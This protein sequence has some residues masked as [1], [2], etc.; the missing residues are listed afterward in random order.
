MAEYPTIDEPRED[1]VYPRAEPL[2]G[3]LPSWARSE[4]WIRWGLTVG[5]VL[6]L[7]GLCSTLGGSVAP[8][9][10]WIVLALGTGIPSLTFWARHLEHQNTLDRVARGVGAGPA[11][12]PRRAGGTSFGVGPG[13]D[14]GHRRDDEAVSEQDVSYP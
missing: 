1:V 2:G 7:A 6:A 13:R 9:L 5:Y 3:P 14:D 8:W 12:T 10:G 4:T 11:F